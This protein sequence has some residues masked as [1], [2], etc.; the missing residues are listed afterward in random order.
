V[1]RDDEGLPLDTQ[2]TDLA[3]ESYRDA[4]SQLI[5]SLQEH[6]NRVLAMTGR[7]AEVPELLARNDAV[8]YAARA[9]DDATIDLTGTAIPWNYDL[10]EAVREEDNPHDA[11]A[12]HGVV[13]ILRREDYLVT[14]PDRVIEAGRSA[15]LRTWPNDRPDDAAFR[16]SNL[17]Q[18]LYELLHARGETNIQEVFTEI[19]GLVVGNSTILFAQPVDQMDPLT[20]D[21]FRDGDGRPL[22]V[23]FRF[24]TV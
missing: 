10:D 2:W 15:Y 12:Y 23:I 18:A 4:A 16:V 19:G 21:P 6:A 14:D 17:G 11:V 8:A 1:T 13:A 9:F 22:P 3:R 7:Q 24:T 20:E 5:A